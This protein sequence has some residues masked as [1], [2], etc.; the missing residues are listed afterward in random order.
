MLCE[1]LGDVASFVSRII[2]AL[3]PNRAGELLMFLFAM[4]ADVSSHYFI[5]Y[6]KTPRICRM[7]KCCEQNDIFES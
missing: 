4:V 7:T 6:S 5:T 3:I 2:P 1:I